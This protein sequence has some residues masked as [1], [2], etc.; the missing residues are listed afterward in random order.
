MPFQLSKSQHSENEFA[1]GAW[2]NP[3][4]S[5]NSVQ[6]TGYAAEPIGQRMSAGG[7]RRT[8][9]AAAP[10]LWGLSNSLFS[11]EAF[12]D[13]NGLNS[14]DLLE[15]FKNMAMYL[16]MR[17]QR[18]YRSLLFALLSI[19]QLARLLYIFVLDCFYWFYLF[20]HFRIISH[21]QSFS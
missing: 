2:D 13:E 10:A 12:R 20:Y 6:Q 17:L 4:N 8:F 11:V 9:F 7:T 21:P 14:V 3:S 15:G 5:L 16:G 18:C 1:V 19:S